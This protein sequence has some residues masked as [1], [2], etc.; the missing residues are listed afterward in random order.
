MG[1][2]NVYQFSSPRTVGEG[3]RK[4]LSVL[5]SRAASAVEN[6]FLFE[7]LR[8]TFKETIQG[9][10]R[11]IEAKDKYTSGHS[12]R[13]KLYTSIIADG[14]G[15]DQ[16]E[17]E[18]IT[19][20]SLVHDIGKLSVDLSTLNSTEGL[21]EDQI[22]LFRLHPTKG[23]EILEP[24][25][26]FA[27]IVPMVY[28]HHEN[29]DGS[30][31]PLGIGGR[32]IPFG[33]RIIAVA[34]SYDAMTSDRAYRRSLTHEIAL[35]ELAKCARSQFDPEVVEIFLEEIRKNLKTGKILELLKDLED[36]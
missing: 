24:I 10:A 4:L 5:A 16:K 3:Q 27:E 34:D 15:L 25:T 7:D 17:R 32:D 11:S 26:I 36:E 13:V 33:A 20:A 19:E 29:Y 18:L 12:N 14:F 23:K 31:Y 35:K 2:I 1:F 6:A 22:L 30:G 8:N 9:F 28:H 21:S